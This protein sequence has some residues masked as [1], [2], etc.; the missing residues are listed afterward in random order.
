MVE[1]DSAIGSNDV[2][3]NIS[4]ERPKIENLKIAA[5][6]R[7]LEQDLKAQIV[8]MKTNFMNEIYELRSE[9]VGLEKQIW[10][11]LVTNIMFKMNS[12]LQ[13][14]NQF[15][16]HELQQKQLVI[17]NILDMKENSLRNHYNITTPMAIKPI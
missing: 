17:E 2:T 5:L 3:V 14:E 12:L 1:Q 15:V 10:I 16:K 8:V 13:Q 7:D 6:A 4:V 9:I 11:D